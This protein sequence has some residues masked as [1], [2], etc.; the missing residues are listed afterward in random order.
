MICLVGKLPV[1]QVGRHQV[2]SYDTAWIDVALQ[3]AAHSCDRSDF[4]FIDDIRGFFDALRAQ[5][6]NVHKT[7]PRTQ[8]VYKCPKINS[9][10]QRG[11]NFVMFSLAF[12]I[13][14]IFFYMILP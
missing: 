11:S 1:L 10:H 6:A 2:A 12:T 14:S 5:L 8:K 13:I 7:V 3:R 4:P 9:F